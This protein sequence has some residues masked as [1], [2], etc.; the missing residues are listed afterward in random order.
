MNP[1]RARIEH[2]ITIRKAECASPKS[3]VVNLKPQTHHRSC[4]RVG[5]ARVSALCTIVRE[6]HRTALTPH[7]ANVGVS[8]TKTFR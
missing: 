4:L 1:Y 5:D 2:V 6:P 8:P 3:D 7:E